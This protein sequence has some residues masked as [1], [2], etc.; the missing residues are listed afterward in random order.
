MNNSTQKR[1]AFTLIELLVVIAIIAILAAI[2]FPVFARAR[3]NAR[4][5]SCASNLKQIALGMI[6]YNQDSDEKFPGVYTGT[7][8]STGNGQG[9]SMIVQPYVKSTQ[10][11]QCP[12]E[13]NGV[14][15]NY[16]NPADSQWSDYFYNRYMTGYKNGDTSAAAFTG[17]SSIADLSYASNTIMLG[18][19]LTLHSASTHTGNSDML[20]NLPCTDGT[21]GPGLNRTDQTNP[22]QRHLEGANY[23]FADGH[24]KWMKQRAFGNGCT[25]PTGSNA[26]FALK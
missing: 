20:S 6:Q 22:S 25:T 17:G 9:W 1:P 2:L 19:Y 12:S 21:P 8:F 5:S 15:T 16:L 23:A 18:D 10:I 26:T 4:R 14:A 3:E 11:F 7:A 24:V 13:P